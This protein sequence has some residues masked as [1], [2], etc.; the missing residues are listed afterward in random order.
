MVNC[1]WCF[2]LYRKGPLRR[3]S[4]SVRVRKEEI[5][6]RIT[7]LY[8]STSWP[9]HPW[10]LQFI[11]HHEN[12]SHARRNGQRYFSS[13]FHVTSCQMTII[14]K[15]PSSRKKKSDCMLSLF[16]RLCWAALG[17]KPWCF[18]CTRE[19]RN[20]GGKLIH[21]DAQNHA[22]T[23]SDIVRNPKWPVTS[24][25]PWT[26][27]ERLVLGNWWVF[28]YFFIIIIFFFLQFFVPICQIISWMCCDKHDSSITL[29]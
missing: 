10:H 14:H 25:L 29:P 24:L 12:V 20:A 7:T 9:F 8:W 17:H 2:W 28:F 19:T 18:V 27:L 13:H 21:P 16:A 1:L 23:L 15:T 11:Y 6:P 26:L 22:R 3:R 5:S 4:I